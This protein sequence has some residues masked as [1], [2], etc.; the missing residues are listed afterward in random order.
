MFTDVAF[1]ETTSFSLS[2]IV[3]SSREDDD[4]LVYY[5]SIPV[6]TSALILVKPPITQVYSR[7]QNPLVSSP[8]PAA[9]TLDPV[10]FDDLPTALRKGKR[11]CVHPIS[12]FCS[13][14]RLSSHS[15]SFIASLDSLSS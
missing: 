2:S 15:C 12:S 4:L 11:Q 3:M 8:T 7:R 6:P 5:V 9:S 13:Y 1:F 14:N 10:S